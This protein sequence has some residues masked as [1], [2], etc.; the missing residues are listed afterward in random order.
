M[1]M[2][3]F[4]ASTMLLIVFMMLMAVVLNYVYADVAGIICM[5]QYG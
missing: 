3:A 2:H 4:L 5:E 1:M